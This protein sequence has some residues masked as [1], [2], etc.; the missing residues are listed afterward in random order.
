MLRVEHQAVAV[1][2][3]FFATLTWAQTVQDDWVAPA[4]P[5][6]TSTLTI[7][8]SYMITWNSSLVDTFASYL[9]DADVNS[10]DL[11]ITDY[12]LHV[13]SHLIAARQNLGSIDFISW[14]VDV[15]ADEL[16]GTD[17]WVFRWLPQDVDYSETSE[18]VSSPGFFLQNLTESA[19]TTSSSSSSSSS[20]PST[21]SAVSTSSSA[22]PSSTQT[23]T[24]VTAPVTAAPTASQPPAVSSSGSLS[25]GSKAGIAIGAI[26]GAALLLGLGWFLAHS[27]GNKR[28][29]ASHVATAP[30]N[31]A[32]VETKPHVYQ[33]QQHLL[34]PPGQQMYRYSELDTGGTVP[35]PA[36]ELPGH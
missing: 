9:P 29:G 13:Y 16:L 4:A 12:N 34:K 25:T 35:V 26:A 7:G 36:H 33:Q 19:A 28:N 10:V 3:F 11:W 32:E 14:R 27:L 30:S 6:F 1:F 20:A 24:S 23:S 17:Q 21:P 31:S 8:E 15:P 22:E 5:D 18:Q 2:L